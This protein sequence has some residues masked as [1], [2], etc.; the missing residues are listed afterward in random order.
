VSIDLYSDVLIKF[1]RV[2]ALKTAQPLR[3]RS[4]IFFYLAAL[5]TIAILLRDEARRVLFNGMNN[6]AECDLIKIYQV[7]ITIHQ[8]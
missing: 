4:G 5:L 8:S 2:K 1:I 6:F 7:R 3:W